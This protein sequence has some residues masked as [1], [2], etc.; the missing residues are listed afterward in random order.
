MGKG[1]EGGVRQ[2]LKLSLGGERVGGT[3]ADL[4]CPLGMLMEMI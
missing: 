2:R 1:H 4:G 3:S